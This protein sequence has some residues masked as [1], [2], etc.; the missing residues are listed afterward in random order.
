MDAGKRPAF[1]DDHAAPLIQILT[2]LFLAFSTLS[3]VAHFATKK[4]MSRPLA[5]GD[6]I[7]LAAL[8][9]AVGQAATFLCPAGQAI[10]NSETDL[11]E[12]TIMRA[13]KAMYSGDI[14]SI[15]AIIAAKSSLLIPFLSV[16]PDLLHQRMMYTTCAVTM[17]WGFSAVLLIAF[18]CPAP[19]RWE[20]TNP[21]CMDIRAV[22]TYNAIMNII[23]DLALA[24]VP[25]LMVM[26]L[27]LESDR[28]LTL[29]V[30]FW[31]R[32]S[33]VIASA[34]QI[35]FI[36]TLPFTSTNL[37]NCIWR[38][39]VCGQVVQVTSIM[40]STIPFLKPF[41]LS[42]ESGFLSA[43]NVARTIASIMWGHSPVYLVRRR[44]VD[45]VNSIENRTHALV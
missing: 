19:Q 39:V 21:R 15:L 13:W 29:L 40:S 34:V 45:L 30:G 6:F 43:G 31:C 35:G 1:Q 18:Q 3:I 27:Q 25:T 28:R 36:R 17:L 44:W 5:R 37:L 8:I 20:I 41:L 10:G 14:L 24:I 32:I 26:P 2:W 16:T 9:L 42:L 11:E 4:A 22:R 33:V 23:T 12:E 7:L 38:V